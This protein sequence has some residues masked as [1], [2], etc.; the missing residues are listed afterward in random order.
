[1]LFSPLWPQSSLLFDLIRFSSVSWSKLWPI[2]LP[3][4]SFFTLLTNRTDVETS[5]DKLSYLCYCAG[6]STNLFALW[7]VD[8]KLIPGIKNLFHAD[9]KLVIAW[10]MREKQLRQWQPYTEAVRSTLGK[11]KQS[12]YRLS[13]WSIDQLFDQSFQLICCNFLLWAA[14][15]TSTIIE[16]DL[17]NKLPSTF[18]SN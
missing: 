16:K 17:H 14:V 18:L 7:G 11:R 15:A 13:D 4:V 8:C 10:L 1:M 12:Y 6:D 3:S 5:T 9:D 2:P